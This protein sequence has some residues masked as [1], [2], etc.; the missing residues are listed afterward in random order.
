MAPRRVL[1]AGMFDLANYGDLLFPLLARQRLEPAGIEV[2]AVAPRAGPPPMPG[3]APTIGL[4][5]MLAAGRE[6]DAVLIGG[7]YIIHTHP[8]DFFE[9]YSAA[10]AGAWAGPGLWLGATL[11]AC[12]SGAR[13]LWNAPGVPHPFG[14]RRR[15]L[16]DAALRAADYL[17]LRDRGAAELLA[18]P[19][20]L[21]VAIVP[22]PAAGLAALWPR[23]R[24]ARDAQGLLARK[25]VAPDAR[26]LALHLRRRSVAGLDLADL[27]AS[28]RA[29]AARWRLTPLL[30]AVGQGHDDAGLAREF[31]PLL[32]P[33]AVLLDDPS[34]LREVAAALAQA[35]LYVGASLHGYVTCAA[36]G[37]PGVLVARPAYRKFA[38]FLEHTGRTQD[39]ARDWRQ[40]LEVAERHLAA[41]EAQA[42]PPRVLAALD[43]HW[44]RIRDGILGP[45]RHGA[46][47]RDFLDAVLRSGLEAGG[48]GWALAPMLGRPP[49]LP[50]MTAREPEAASLHARRWSA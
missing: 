3:A 8:L 2:T 15:P 32:G 11:A 7:G 42:M 20:G 25:G 50:A 35:R 47:R 6:F 5:D 23:E 38:G 21:E 28:L 33:S 37:V 34:E 12:L 48:P 10:E 14:P 43:A 18:P 1:V 44:D 19:A 30:V 16:I 13:I 24:L 45:A 17:S 49:G 4:G 27:A 9:A 36:Y 29:F 31:A 39:L 40:A 26:L 46:A 41:P 22:D